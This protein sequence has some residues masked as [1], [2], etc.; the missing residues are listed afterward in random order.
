MIEL[1]SRNKKVMA[2]TYTRRE[3]ISLIKGKIELTQFDKNP[4][5]KILK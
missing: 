5:I 4:Q 1:E 3:L 2:G